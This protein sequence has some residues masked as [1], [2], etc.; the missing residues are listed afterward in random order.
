MRRRMMMQTTATHDYDVVWDYTM[1]FPEDNGFTLTAS[2]TDVD[3][4]ITQDGVLYI[5]PESSMSP[6]FEI[7][8][9]G[10]EYCNDAVFEITVSIR[11]FTTFTNGLRLMISD[12][13]GGVQVYAHDEK[14]LYQDGATENFIATLEKNVQYVCRVERKS[15][16]NKVYLNGNMIHESETKSWKYNTKTRLIFQNGGEY[17][18]KSIKFKKIS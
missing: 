9:T 8:P 16:K 4:E 7:V 5:L 11:E 14:L 6:Y 2:Y 13:S 10:Y 17:L 1:G 18:L 12:G 15:N 3:P